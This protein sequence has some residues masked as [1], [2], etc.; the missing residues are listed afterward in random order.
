MKYTAT[1]NNIHIVDSYAIPK[2]HYE[3][4]LAQIENEHPECEVFKRGYPSLKREW[5]THTLLYDLNIQRERT[6]DV[7]LD[8]PQKWYYRIGYAV[9]GTIALIFVK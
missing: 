6:K 3:R 2:A 9:I 7:D 4:S 5:A 1:P 8:Y